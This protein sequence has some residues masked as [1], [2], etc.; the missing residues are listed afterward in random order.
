MNEFK[1]G[2]LLRVFIGETDK[3]DGIPL[4]EWIVR[5]AKQ[6][7]LAG[8]TVFRAIEGYGGH[9]QVHTAKILQLSTDLPIVVE[10][11]D[12]MDKV[13]RFMPVL[14]GAVSD[15]MVVL[16]RVQMKFYRSD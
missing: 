2:Y 1:E 10:I 5:S 4:Y 14:D 13:E 7:K 6:E 9:S 8:A 12:I 16:E 11:I 15:G 3:K